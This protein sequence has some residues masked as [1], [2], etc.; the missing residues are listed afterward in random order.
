MLGSLNTSPL[1]TVHRQLGARLVGYAGWEMPLQFS[2]VLEEHRA[3]RCA[4]GLFDVSHMGEIEIRGG[5]A[6]SLVQ[7]L[8]CNDAA[9]LEAG[10]VQYSALTTAEGTFVDDIMVY[11][12][13][14]NDFLLVVNAGNTDKD[15]AWIAGHAEGDVEVVNASRRWAL[16]ALQG[17][18]AVSILR[19]HVTID[20]GS[21]RAFRFVEARVGAMEA[22]ISRTGYT[23]EDGFEIYLDAE[24]ATEVFRALLDA[25]KPEGLLPCGL[26]ARDTLRLEAAMRLYG[27]DIDETTTVLEAGLEGIVKWEKG[28]FMGRAALSLQK[29]K[30]VERRLV[31]FDLSDPGVPRHGYA[32]RVDGAQVGSVTSG[33]LAP[34]LRRPIGLAYVPDHLSAPGSRLNIDIRGREAAAVVVRV[35][36]YKRGR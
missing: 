21:L 33:T 12:R 8:T 5:E 13:G 24:G 28:E 35:P 29:E 10:H 27:N 32:V 9:R 3:V 19:A 7:H 2:S 26:G 6:L 36:F 18:R 17:P 30:G 16:L 31:G 23:G 15:F 20:P 25:G 14:P 4:A 34:H 1:E 22:L 11:R